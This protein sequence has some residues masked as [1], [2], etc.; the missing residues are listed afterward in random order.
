MSQ[1][2]LTLAGGPEVQ[3]LQGACTIFGRTEGDTI[4]NLMEMAEPEIR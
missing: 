1:S 3:G 4:Y 2:S